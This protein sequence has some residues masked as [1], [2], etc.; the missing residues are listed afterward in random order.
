MMRGNPFHQ[1]R[2]MPA[3]G[4]IGNRLPDEDRLSGEASVL[5]L[6]ILD[7]NPSGFELQGLSSPSMYLVRARIDD[8]KINSPGLNVETNSGSIGALSEIRFKDLTTESSAS[9]ID[10][11]LDSINSDPDR[12]LG[13]YNRANNLSLKY[14]AFQLLP[15]IGNSKAMQMVKE[16]GGSGWSDFGQIDKSCGI[17]SAKLLAERYVGEMQDPSES[18]SLL[19]L[20]VRSGI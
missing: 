3:E 8:D 7:R 18:P 6:D 17:D 12:H 16:R 19:D 5:V 11:V 1:S 4:P 9:I 20:L 15:G 14:H 2:N 10:A 13:F